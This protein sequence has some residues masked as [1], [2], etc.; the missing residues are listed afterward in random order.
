MIVLLINKNVGYFYK[1]STCKIKI[2][3]VKLVQKRRVLIIPNTYS[4]CHQK[5][6]VQAKEHYLLTKY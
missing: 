6:H 4:Q 5:A 3:Q 2:N 1:N